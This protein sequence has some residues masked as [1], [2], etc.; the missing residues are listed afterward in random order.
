VDRRRLFSLA[1]GGA[2]GLS[3]AASIAAGFQAAPDLQQW[4]FLSLAGGLATAA[5][6]ATAPQV[7][8]EKK[9][10]KDWTVPGQTTALVEKECLLAHFQLRA[11]KS[12]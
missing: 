5:G 2:L 8:L 12:S 4:I 6:V 10:L 9:S 1:V 7:D 3:A 11:Q